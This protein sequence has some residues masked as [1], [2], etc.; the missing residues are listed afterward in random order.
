M[1]R[2]Y[3]EFLRG[4]QIIASLSLREGLS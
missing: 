2:V 4:L 1:I 3:Y